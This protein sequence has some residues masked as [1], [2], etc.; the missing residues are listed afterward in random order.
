MFIL[1]ADL[2]SAPAIHPL[3]LLLAALA[4]DAWIGEA[5][6]PLARLPHPVR[7]IGAVVASLDRRL[8]RDGRSANDLRARGGLSVVVVVALVF[9]VGWVVVWFGRAV[10]LGWV[11]ELLLTA[12]LLAQFSL[13]RHVRDVADG[14]AMGLDDGRAAVAHIVG[15]DVNQLD[16]A[17]V[18]RAAI[19]SC[20]ENFSDGIVAPVFWCVLFGLPGLLAYKAV[21][22]MDSMIGYRTPKYLYFGMAAARLDDLMNYLPAR[23]SGLFI[24]AGAALV[25]GASPAAALKTMRR[26]ARKHRSPNAGW[27]E[28][29]MA[30]AL[31]LALAG[32][33]RYPMLTVD[34]PWIGDGRKE[35]DVP[36][37]Y[38]SLAVLR[39]ACGMMA[40]AVALCF[41]LSLVFAE[42]KP[43]ERIHPGDRQQEL[44]VLVAP[45]VGGDADGG[46]HLRGD[47]HPAAPAGYEDHHSRA[48]ASGPRAD[49]QARRAD[50][51][52]V[53]RHSRI[54]GGAG[55]R[56]ETVA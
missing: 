22:T 15:R 49:P 56:R 21:N 35:A 33:R 1:G 47:R 55:S 54:P 48:L 13:Y 45:P 11:V 23:L 53:D 38:G 14:L 19:E 18:A 7:L 44:L 20:A 6:G 31:G 26:D 37:V 10:P 17:G 3:L 34:D 40:L 30:G 27:P 16:R 24:A 25:R 51:L 50:D 4:L 28:S 12:S 8:N 36:D 29:A 2:M 42:D 32:P 43:H 9:A 46:D 41:L 5:R 52:G 39:A